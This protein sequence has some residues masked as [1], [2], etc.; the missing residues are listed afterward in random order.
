MTVDFSK[1]FKP[2]MA[3]DLLITIGFTLIVSWFLFDE[4]QTLWSAPGKSI[5]LAAS[6]TLIW[7]VSRA[8]TTFKK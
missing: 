1:L 2:E 7:N 8:I 5:V 6:A 3:L 4:G